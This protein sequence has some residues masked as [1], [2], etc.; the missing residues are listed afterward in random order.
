MYPVHYKQNDTLRLAFKSWKK[1][2]LSGFSPEYSGKEF[3]LGSSNL[4]AKDD[5]VM[6]IPLKEKVVH[7]FHL[8]VST[9]KYSSVRAHIPQNTLIKYCKEEYNVIVVG[10][11]YS[12]E[13]VQCLYSLLEKTVQ[14][15]IGDVESFFTKYPEFE[16]NTLVNY[17]LFEL[18]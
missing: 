1:V 13:L 5:Y 11:N 16:I 12:V 10:Y 18:L 9:G 15:T 8:F 2:T 3:T 4:L 17:C 7:I 6:S 14:L